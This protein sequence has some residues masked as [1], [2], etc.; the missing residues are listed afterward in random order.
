MVIKY[1][2]R[3]EIKMLYV[4]MEKIDNKK[5]KF[6]SVN[7]NK[8]VQVFKSKKEAN[9]ERIYLQPDYANKLKVMSIK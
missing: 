2:R 7:T 6:V 9:I 8:T 3:E 4:I 1:K 5:S